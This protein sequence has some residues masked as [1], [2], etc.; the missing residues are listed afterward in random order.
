VKAV[1]N[2]VFSILI[3]A[4]GVV[5]LKIFGQKPEVPTQEVSA[6]GDAVL[7]VTEPVK[8]F[9]RSFH[10]SVDGEAVTYRVVT[11]GAEVEGR[12][13]QKTD[14]VRGGT[15]LRKGDLLFEIDPTNY[16]LDVER[17]TAQLAQATEEQNTVSVDI[18]N[19]Q[20]LIKLADEE[21]SLQK[22]QLARMKQL[23]A[24]G[25][26]NETEVETAMKQEL[27]ARNGLQTL[28]NQLR[29]LTQQEK[30]R[31]ANRRLVEAQLQR[32]K[33]DLQRCRVISPLDG[34]VVDDIVE[35]GD[36]LKSG[37]PLVHISD[38]S[39]MEIKCQLRAE[40]LAWVWR[41]A[42][43]KSVPIPYPAGAEESD[44]A[45][46]ELTQAPPF[47]PVRLPKVD[48]EVAFV[49]EGVETIWD[50]YIARIEGTGIDR[51]TRTFPCRILVEEPE[52]TRFSDSAGGR[53]IAP[54]TLLS[55]MYVVVR[56]PIASSVPLLQLPVEAIR[57]GGQ[58]WVM[59]DNSLQILEASVAHTNNDFALVR[60]DGSGFHDGDRVIVSPLTSVRSGMAVR[61][62]PET[63]E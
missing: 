42:V 24:R 1:T 46:D 32:A 33:S 52:K 22:N 59:R 18:Q 26:A 27:A 44:G 55:G 28:Q 45:A 40:E 14:R 48:C 53:A 17:L 10:I 12:V 23:K 11:V 54:P 36:Y 29:S 51:D 35:E 43:E 63:T 39:R 62:E 61:E 19:A 60:R 6:T 21:W 8:S 56:I 20:A 25:T 2:V 15:F 3:L 31:A 38:G 49:F 30:T 34:R 50:G 13:T 58:I 41:Q 7:V 57:P 16:Q 9:D 5:G 37:E 47:D 4:A